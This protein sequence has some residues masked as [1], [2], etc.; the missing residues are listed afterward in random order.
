MLLWRQGLES[1]VRN[2]KYL[3]PNFDVWVGLRPSQLK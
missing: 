3:Y 1:S 2:L